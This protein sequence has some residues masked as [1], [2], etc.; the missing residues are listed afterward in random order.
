MF[1]KK[2]QEGE[3]KAIYYV[4]GILTVFVGFIVGQIPYGFTITLLKQ[5]NP[6]KAESLQT[7]ML[8]VQNTG[9]SNNTVFLFNL[10][11]FLFGMAALY[12]VIRYFH[13]R[14]FKSLITAAPKFRY[15]R[16]TFAMLVWFALNILSELVIYLLYP[17]NYQ[18]NIHWHTF[19]PLLIISLLLIPFQASL[20]EILI[21]G[22]LLQAFTSLLKKPW[23]AIILSALVFAS[24]H[25]SN[26]EIK[27][28]G[29]LVTSYYFLFGLLAA[30]IAY[31]DN[32]LEIPMAIHIINNLYGAVIVSYKDSVF[33]TDALIQV[34]STNL[35]VL[36]TV[37]T[38]MILV[39]FGLM[40]WRYKWRLK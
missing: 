9:I 39:F 38:A 28:F 30:Y 8:N 16:F 26:P 15:K 4:L 40:L 14:S 32:G 12:I 35:S 1:L 18:L 3:N 17:E 27:E 7:A 34:Q 22:Y 6:A 36:M 5:F 19:L 31:L 23:L 24:L 37:S 13:K 20:E 2:Y 11:P 10:I 33:S 21:R 25:L 29:L